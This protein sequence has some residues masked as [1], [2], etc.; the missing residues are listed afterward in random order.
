MIVYEYNSNHIHGEPI[1]YFN[2][3]DLTRVYKKVHKNLK[4]WGLQP[5]LHILDIKVSSL[6]NNFMTKVYEKF[7][8]VIPHLHQINAAEWVI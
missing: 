5:Q 6:L 8:F 1:K 3:A 2:N 7:Q 4:S